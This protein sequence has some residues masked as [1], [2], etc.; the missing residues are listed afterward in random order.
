MVLAGAIIVL[1]IA[2][3]L[4]V[5]GFILPKLN[6]VMQHRMSKETIN[7]PRKGD[8]LTVANFREKRNAIAQ[9]DKA[10]NA[11]LSVEQ[12]RYCFVSEQSSADVARG[13]HQTRSFDPEISQRKDR[14]GVCFLAARGRDFCDSTVYISSHACAATAFMRSHVRRI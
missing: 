9:I 13:S 2:C 10:P 1:W 4:A 8:R 14:V 3:L 12:R 7:R 6:V 11:A 5:T